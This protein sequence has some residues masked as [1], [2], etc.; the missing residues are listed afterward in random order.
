MSKI[1]RIVAFKHPEVEK[2]VLY[3]QNITTEE[4]LDAVK[5]A[6]ELGA[7]LMSVRGFEK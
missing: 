5:R 2:S 6:I 7:N 1:W 4:L 3:R